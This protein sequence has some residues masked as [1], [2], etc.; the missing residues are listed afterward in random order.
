VECLIDGVACRL[1]PGGRFILTFRDLTGTL[2]G[3]DRFIPVRGDDDR[4]MTCFLEYEADTVVVHDLIHL[5]EDGAW[6]LHMSSYRKLRLAPD[7]VRDGLSRRGF[8]VSPAQS[9]GR[10]TL[11]AATR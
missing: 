3:T 8:A 9:A 2:H 10:L 7:R 11:I 1:K 4:L 6:V 5:R